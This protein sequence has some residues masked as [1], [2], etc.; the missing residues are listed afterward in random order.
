MKLKFTIP[1][2]PLGWQRPGYNAQT[3][4]K[5]TQ[6]QTRNR[7][8]EIKWLYRQ[9]CGNYKYPAGTPLFIG[10]TVNFPIPKSTS[11][12][13]REKMI[14]SEIYPTKKP[15]FDNI[16]KLICDALNGIAY[17]DDR[18]IVDAIVMKRYGIEEKT[19]VILEDL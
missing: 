13:E 12:K 8:N 2:K 14:N 1:G 5:F 17:E 11:I 10:I 9:Q 6:T 7:E 3:G 16:A 19:V 15:D 18:F 4:A